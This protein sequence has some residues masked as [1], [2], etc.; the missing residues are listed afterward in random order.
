M[1]EMFEY[2]TETNIYCSNLLYEAMNMSQLLTQEYSSLYNLNCLPR[3]NERGLKIMHLNY[4]QGHGC[5]L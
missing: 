1:E 5:R 4:K 2:K 3:A